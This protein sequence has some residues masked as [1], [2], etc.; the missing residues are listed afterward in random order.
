MNLITNEQQDELLANGR[1]VMDAI[2]AGIAATAASGAP[3]SAM[4][5]SMTWR[6]PRAPT[7]VAWFATFTSSPRSASPPTLKRRSPEVSS[8]PEFVTAV[9]LRVGVYCSSRAVRAPALARDRRVRG[10]RGSA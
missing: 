6:S 5:S 2:R 3:H 7:T 10:R 8:S 4:C 1:A 9:G